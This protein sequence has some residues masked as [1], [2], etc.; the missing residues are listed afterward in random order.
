[1]NILDKLNPGPID[2]NKSRDTGLAFALLS[3]VLY[4][5]AGNDYWIIAAFVFIIIAILIPMVLKPLAIFWFGLAQALGSIS[6]VIVLGIVF[7]LIVVP[8]GLI[9]KLKGK[10][11][12]GL[13]HW[14]EKTKS[15]FK[16][17][18]HEFTGEDLKFPY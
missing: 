3:I 18:E 16:T 1:M 11:R 15:H 17:R 7:F 6:S 12:L 2:K 10:D 13:K 14:Q 9:R 4:W 5:L 8:A